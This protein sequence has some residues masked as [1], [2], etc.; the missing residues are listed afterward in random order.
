MARNSR[1]RANGAIKA[2]GK[3]A[4]QR[5]RPPN[6]DEL[7]PETLIS[8]A[9]AHGDIPAT[10]QG[11]DRQSRIAKR[12]YELAQ[13]R[14]FTPGAE[15]DDWLQAESEIDACPR[16]ARPEDQFTG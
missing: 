3:S 13:R 10:S 7:S 6:A 5:N 14:G 8:D 11:G 12:A 9:P 4:V 1:D 2:D 16:P 15:L